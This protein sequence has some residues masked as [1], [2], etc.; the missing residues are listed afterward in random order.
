MPNLGGIE[1]LLL[2]T[3]ALFGVLLLVAI[4]RNVS[5][6]QIADEWAATHGV[7]LT[8]ETRDLAL[9]YLSR[10]RRFRLIGALIGLVVPFGT[11]T[12]GLELI[13]GYLL[14][15]VIAEFTQ[16]RPARESTRAAALLPRSL[17]SYVPRYV[18]VV[19]RGAAAFAALYAVI[20]A[21]GPTRD[22]GTWHV[23]APVGAV[24]AVV[25][26]LLIELLLRR[27]IARPQAAGSNELV[28]IDDALRSSSVH[29]AAG[30]GIGASLLL[31]AA[32]SWVISVT[33]D[34]QL[35]RWVFPA[36]GAAFA[37]TAIVVWLR[38]GPASAWKVQRQAAETRA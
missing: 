24:A 18:P 38:L 5:R 3:M 37:L 25:L 10:S 12:P 19:L 4:V 9:E 31:L 29:A 22:L 21:F 30:A 1:L 23:S 35:L 6:P 2:V 7:V 34:I 28:A 26:P 8:E 15:A 36:L 20:Y 11:N 27:M 13:L 16:K 33:S 14:G 17:T 32:M